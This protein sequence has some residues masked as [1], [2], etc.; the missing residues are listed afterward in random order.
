MGGGISGRPGAWAE[1][2]DRLGGWAEV[3]SRPGMWG[4]RLGMWATNRGNMPTMLPRPS[5]SD[6]G[7]TRRA[8]P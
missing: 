6:D 4:T 7:R 5:R 8:M 1:A 3:R 2:E